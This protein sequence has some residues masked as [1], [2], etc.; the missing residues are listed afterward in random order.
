MNAYKVQCL[1]EREHFRHLGWV[2]VM[3]AEKG[4]RLNLHDDYYGISTGWE[5]LAVYEDTRTGDEKTPEALYVRVE[6]K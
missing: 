6:S 4:A 5:V 3:I 2:P 1:L